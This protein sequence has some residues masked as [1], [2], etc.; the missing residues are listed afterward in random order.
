MRV[1]K[2]NS[3]GQLVTHGASYVE[4]ARLACVDK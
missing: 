1:D 3:R 4:D 2:R